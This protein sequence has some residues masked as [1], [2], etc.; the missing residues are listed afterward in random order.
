MPRNSAD[1]CVYQVQLS[2]TSDKMTLEAQLIQA[3]L[4]LQLAERGKDGSRMVTLACRGAYEVRLIQP[5]QSAC[6]SNTFPFWIELF[7]HDRQ[8][9]IDSVG[10]HVINDAVISAERLIAQAEEGGRGLDPD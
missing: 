7:D 1:I 3:R 2:R 8:V 9:S 4:T 6:A 10:S 5:F